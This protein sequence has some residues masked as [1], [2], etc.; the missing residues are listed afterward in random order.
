MET[1]LTGSICISRE[2]AW[3]VEKGKGKVGALMQ[4]HP[5]FWVKSDEKVLKREEMTKTSGGVGGKGG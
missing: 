1:K 3:S 4:I 2:I 5:A